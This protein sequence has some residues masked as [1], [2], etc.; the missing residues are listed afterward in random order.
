MSTLNQILE[1]KADPSEIVSKLVD[2]KNWDL[3]LNA[4]Q[5]CK[6]KTFFFINNVFS[7]DQQ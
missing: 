6:Q 5:Q 3:L 4:L 7:S 2:A 1:G